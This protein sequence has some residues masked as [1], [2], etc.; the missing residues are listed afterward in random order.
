MTA[1]PLPPAFHVMTKPRGAICNLDCEYCFYLRKEDLYQGSSFRMGDETLESYVR[2]YIAAQRAPEV[3]FAWQGGEPT[4]MG[5][6]FFRKAVAYQRKYARPGMRIE[7]ALQTNGTLLDDEWCRFF[8]EN[9]FLIGI[10]LDGPREAHDLYRKDKG[11]APTFDRVL[12]AVELLKKHK[13]DF[14]VLTCVSAANVHQPLEVYRFLRDEIGAQFIQFIPI[15]ERDNGTGFQEGTALTPRSI[16]GKQYGDFLIAIFDEWVRRDVGMVFVQ[17]FDTALGR[18]LGAP[19][20]LCVFQETCG[21]ALAM[22]HNGDLYSCDHFVEP[23]HRLGN[24]LETP[25]AEMAGSMQQRKFGLDKKASLPRY[26]RECPVLFACNGGCPKDRTD[27]TPDG[28]AGLNHLCDGFKAFFTH[29]DQPMRQMAGLLRQR[30]PAAE[31]MK[32]QI[33]KEKP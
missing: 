22:E 10:S 14:N 12:R 29:I 15:V 18:W 27:L 33:S 20:G 13:V 9:R 2:Q 4:L 7:N 11:G 1:I 17:M 3:N 24:L 5:L 23:R 16:T 8:A 6:D 31:I 19:G 21:L 32:I 26:C 25:L 30:R 28:E